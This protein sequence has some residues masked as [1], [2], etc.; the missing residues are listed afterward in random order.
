MLKKFPAVPDL[1][2][3][4]DSSAEAITLRSRYVLQ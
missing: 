1:F 4:P 2:S 3:S